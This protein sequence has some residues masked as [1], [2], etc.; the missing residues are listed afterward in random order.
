MKKIIVDVIVILAI[1]IMFIVGTPQEAEAR[2]ILFYVED[3]SCYLGLAYQAWY[4]DATTGM[5]FFVGQWCA[6]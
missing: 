2:F 3:T 5:T 6:F 1:L 4:Y